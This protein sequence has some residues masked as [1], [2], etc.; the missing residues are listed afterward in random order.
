MPTSVPKSTSVEIKR[1][2]E[3]A[4]YDLDTVCKILDEGLVCHVGFAQDNQPFVIP[5]AYG[6]I[7]H[8][9]YLHGSIDSRLMQHMQEQPVSISVTLL[10]GLVLARSAFHHSMNYRSVMLIAQGMLVEDV[11]KKSQALKA[12]SDQLLPNRWDDVRAPNKTEM[13]DTAVVAFPITEASA[14]IRTGP[15]TDDDA[16]YKRPTWAGVLPYIQTIGTPEPDSKLAPRIALP[17]YISQCK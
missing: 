8:S 1:N 12:V 3:R 11:R 2:P 17:D 9:L 16:D 7:D 14:K 13:H 10:D 5:M 6:R 15:P 4:K